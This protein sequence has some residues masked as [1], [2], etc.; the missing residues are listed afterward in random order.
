VDLFLATRD[1]SAHLRE[2]LARATPEQLAATMEAVVEEFVVQQA[3][4]LPV[5]E[6]GR[7]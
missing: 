3:L 7:G 2:D 6:M 5:S 1:V 4:L